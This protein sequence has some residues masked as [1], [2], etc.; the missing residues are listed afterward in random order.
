MI[1][2][3]I[4]IPIG[5]LLI[6]FAASDYSLYADF[7]PYELFGIIPASYCRYGLAVSVSPTDIS[8]MLIFLNILMPFVIGLIMLITGIKAAACR[9]RSDIIHHKMRSNSDIAVAT[10]YALTIV[11]SLTL[12]YKACGFDSITD[13]FEYISEYTG[14]ILIIIALICL[15]IYCAVYMYRMATTLLGGAAMLTAVSMIYCIVHFNDDYYS[16]MIH[17]Y[18]MY[19]KG[20]SEGTYILTVIV[21]LVVMLMFI[22]IGSNLIS[23]NYSE[24]YV[25]SMASVGCLIHTVGIL[26]KFSAYFTLNYEFTELL[27]LM[28]HYMILRISSLYLY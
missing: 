22:A 18:T 6:C 26:F 5:F 15:L 27:S 8:G 13:I 10:V 11:L 23:G 28:L 14:N 17:V 19:G 20:M 25:K 16:Y 21:D 2:G 4:R 12:V 24:K 7:M 9:E 1:K 3:L